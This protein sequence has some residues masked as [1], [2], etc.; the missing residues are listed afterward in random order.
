MIAN[1]HYDIISVYKLTD[2]PELTREFFRLT[3]EVVQIQQ[4][5]TI[6]FVK[7]S[8]G[9]WMGIPITCSKKLPWRHAQPARR[10]TALHPW[11]GVLL[12]NALSSSFLPE[13]A[14]DKIS[15]QTTR[16]KLQRESRSAG[17]VYRKNS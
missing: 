14:R 1:I 17:P 8:A 11:E 12:I 6:K 2:D 5:K 16:R 13:P 15:R 7:C 3:D 9:L 10:G 4:E